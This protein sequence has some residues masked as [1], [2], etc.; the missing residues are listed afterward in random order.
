[1]NIPLEKKAKDGWI[2]TY[3][4]SVFEDCLFLTGKQGRNSRRC[5]LIPVMNV[6]LDTQNG[7]AYDYN[8]IPSKAT[9][10]SLLR[11]QSLNK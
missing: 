9:K 6:H 7:G 3:L 8:N 2:C 1:M 11:N 10:W 5:V 4:T